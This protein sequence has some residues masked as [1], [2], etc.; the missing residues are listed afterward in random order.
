MEINPNRSVDSVAPAAGPVK[1]KGAASVEESDTSFEQS[2]GLTAALSSTPDSRADV[3]A[4][5]EKLIA[6][7]SYPSPEVIQRIA[8][9]L[10]GSLIQGGK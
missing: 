4:R 2:A 9:L 5:A 8:N 10:A 1:A 6:S 3:V 7:P